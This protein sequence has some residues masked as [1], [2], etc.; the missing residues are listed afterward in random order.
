MAARGFDSRR[1]LRAPTKDASRRERVR[2][3]AR[4]VLLPAVANDNYQPR[5]HAH[6]RPFARAVRAQGDSAISG[7]GDGDDVSMKSTRPILSCA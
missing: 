5:T 7:R 2:M 4:D 1:F 6:V 3:H